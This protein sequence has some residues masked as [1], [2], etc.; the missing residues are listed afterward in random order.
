[1]TAYAVS[2]FVSLAVSK[3]KKIYLIAPIKLNIN[4]ILYIFF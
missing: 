1:M 2:Q 3:I 4:I